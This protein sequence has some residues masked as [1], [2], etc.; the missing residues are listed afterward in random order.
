MYSVRRY[1]SR[2]DAPHIIA[3]AELRNYVTSAFWAISATRDLE[4]IQLDAGHPA[5]DVE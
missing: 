2:G 3:G 1:L 4:F 5:W